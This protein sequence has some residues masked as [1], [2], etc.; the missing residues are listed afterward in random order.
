MMIMGNEFREL[1][2]LSQMYP[3]TLCRY[4]EAHY[5]CTC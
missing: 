1:L 2:K 4:A 3:L 5:T